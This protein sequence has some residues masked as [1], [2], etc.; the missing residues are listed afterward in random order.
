[1]LVSKVESPHTDALVRLGRRHD[2]RSTRLSGSIAFMVV[3]AAVLLITTL[4]YALA[5]QS[6]P[7]GWQFMGILLNVPDTSQYLSWA[8]ESSRSFLIEDKMTS[9]H[10][11]AVYYNLFF[12]V[13]GHLSALLRIGVAEALQLMRVVS[14]VLYLAAIYWFT[15]LVLTQPRQ[16]W[17]AVL[18]AI[19]GS[20][21]GWLLVLHKFAT[22][23][24]EVAFPLDLYTSEANT[25]LSVLAFPL[26]AMAGGLV[27]LIFGLAAIAFERNSL[28]PAMAAGFLALL[29]GLLHGYDL[30]VVYA[31]VGSV[32]LLML[33]RDRSHWRPLLLAS[34]ICGWSVPAALW[35]FAITHFDPI[36][37]GTL[38]QYANAGVYTPP[39]PHLLILMG[40]P[41]VLTLAGLTA[42]APKMSPARL[43]RLLRDAPPLEL[44]LFVWLLLGSVLLYIPTD[45]QIKMLVDWHVPLSIFATRTLFRV[46]GAVATRFPLFRSRYAVLIIAGATVVA[47]MPTSVY[48]FS[49]RIVDLDRHAY[50]Y[51]LRSD[52]VSALNWLDANTAPSEP[53]LSSLTIGQYIP[54]VAGNNAFLAHWASTLDYYTKQRDVSIF[55]NGATPDSLRKSLIDQYNIGYIFYGTPEREL[56][57]YDPSNS[58]LLRRVFSNSTVA[59]YQVI[60]SR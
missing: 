52:E 40:L 10:G 4:P 24:A 46:I 12:F 9:E 49:W 17:T 35:S 3:T 47:T 19:L 48:L 18:I 36:W 38:E 6:T 21:L 43:S 27:L 26:Q 50:P 58:P 25:F 54:S 7:P 8:R 14:G 55:F 30:V 23:A 33:L 1:V 2:A 60:H 32:A 56:G 22:G 59:V 44:L 15:G 29:L 39:P 16:R 28:R 57:G 20:G 53:V 34:C 37:R 41:L 45:F 42:L 51:Y 11:V 5:Y 31:V 13:V